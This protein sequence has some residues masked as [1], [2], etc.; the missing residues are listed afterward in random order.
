MAKRICSIEG[1]TSPHYGRGWCRQHWNGWYR[2]GDPEVPAQRVPPIEERFWANVQKTETCW[3]WTGTRFPKGYGYLNRG[4]KNR[5]V[6]HVYV[7]RFAYEL[8]VGPIPEGMTI[9]H[10]KANGYISRACVKAIADEHGPAHLEPV[11]LQTNL[12]RGDGPAARNARK[13]HCIHGHPFDEANTYRPKSGGR[14]CRACNRERQARYARN[15]VQGD[16]R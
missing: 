15:R 1:C 2:H 10:I 13:T 16:A 4:G 11:T 6:R 3:L 9:D 7:H 5:P 14:Q 12:M 8:L